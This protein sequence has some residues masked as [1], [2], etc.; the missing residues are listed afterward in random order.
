MESL[1][2]DLV[3]ALGGIATGIG[4][5]WTALVTRNLARATEQSIIEQSQSLREQNERAREQNERFRI[6]L[7]VDLMHRMEERFDSA[8]FQSYR[9]RS[10][11]YVREN[12]LVD[13]DDEEILE[14]QDLDLATEQVFEFFDDL[15]YLCRVGVLPVERVLSR[16]SGLMTAWEF[17]EP[18]VKKRREEEGDPRW[19]EDYEYLYRQSVEAVR[20][21]GGMVD[22]LTREELRE[23]VEANIQYIETGQKPAM[24]EEE[25]KTG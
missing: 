11:T 25:P 13:G 6:N 15:G 18:A 16:Y 9:L 3:I 23:F 10:M 17:W 19:F 20:Q 1:P 24:G 14:A 12:Y 8:R 2:L 7:E 22:R 21:S 4:A 5:I